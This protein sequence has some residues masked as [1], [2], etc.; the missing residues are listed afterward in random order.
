[1][2]RFA[3]IK[4]K[5]HRVFFDEKLKSLKQFL[6]NGN[7][8]SLII[9]TDSNT[10][11]H[12]LPKL[13]DYCNLKTYHSLCLPAGE[14]FKT[15]DS[16]ENLWEQL[17]PVSDRKSV[18]I[19]LGGGM[20]TDIGGFTASVFKRGID[21]IHV[22][23][24][25]LSMIDASVGGKTGVDF[26]NYKNQL[27]TFCQ[28]KA[29]F[30]STEFLNSLPHDELVSGKA[31]MAKH[32]VLNGLETW[33][34]FVL[35]F[36]KTDSVKDQIETAIRFKLKITDK[37]LFDQGK[38]IQ[39]NFG[40]T[41]GHALES[42][43]LLTKKPIPHGFAVAAGMICELFISCK[44]FKLSEDFFNEQIIFLKNNFP[45]IIFNETEIEEILS[46]VASDKKNIGTKIKPVLLKRLGKPH[47]DKVVDLVTVK[48]SLNYYRLL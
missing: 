31:E 7:Y 27:G 29:V 17:L 1:M 46:F 10:K 5:F 11:R 34:E 45:K 40:H 37:D 8:S 36:N 4:G 25:L 48:E 3:V 38:R 42:F 12:C 2:S 20:I 35:N 41:I 15:L 26:A 18:L 9:L 6:R 16:A 19:N 21:F 32:A 43:C 22:P 28:P 24:T 14:E 44:Y 13:V 39:L 23:T 47:M 30:I 33:N